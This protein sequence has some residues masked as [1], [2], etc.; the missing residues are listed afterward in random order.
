MSESDSPTI[1][2]LWQRLEASM[3]AVRVTNACREAVRALEVIRGMGGEAGEAADVA[4]LR[5]QAEL[6]REVDLG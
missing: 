1:L 5:V 2:Q 3:E 4:L 6:A